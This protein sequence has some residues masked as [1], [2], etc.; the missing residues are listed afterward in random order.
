MEALAYTLRLASPSVA[1]CAGSCSFTKSSSFTLGDYLRETGQEWHVSS[2]ALSTTWTKLPLLRKSYHTPNSAIFEFGL[3]PGAATLNLPTSSCVCARVRRPK[4][5]RETVEWPLRADEDDPVLLELQAAVTAEER[6]AA[7]KREEADE[8]FEERSYTPV[9]PEDLPGRFQLLV[10]RYD[11]WGDE[12]YPKTYKPPGLVS[13]ALH[14]LQVG[15]EVEF[16]HVAKNI[17]IRYPFRG[18]KRLNLVCVGSGVAPMIQIL[19]KVLAT[20]GDDTRIVLVY[21][22]RSEDEIMM[23]KRLEQLTWRYA[24]RFKLVYCLGSRYDVDKDRPEVRNRY[25]LFGGAPKREKGWI[26]KDVL[27]RHLAPPGEDSLTLVCG[28]PRV[29]ETLCGPRGDPKVAGTLAALG[30]SRRDVVKL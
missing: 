12:R 24:R 16:R 18:A 23:K 10:R 1:G 2:C 28:L 7:A 25:A 19:E 21:G 5:L 20:P 26:T 14:R 22:N 13:S 6:A 3:P 15:D 27:E 4:S 17:K 30:W 29:Y 8:G 11:A 9:S